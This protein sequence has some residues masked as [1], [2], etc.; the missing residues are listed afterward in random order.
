M[1]DDGDYPLNCIDD[2][3]DGF[4]GWFAISNPRQCNDFCYW[5]LPDSVQQ[6]T[7]NG[8]TNSTTSAGGGLVYA[9]WNTANPHKSTV[10]ST[11]SSGTSYWTCIYDSANDKTLVSLAQDERW[12][13]SFQKYYTPP[14]TT[15]EVVNK[16]VPFPYLKCQ[17]GAG[18]LLSSWS[19]DAVTS[20]TFWE[21]SVVLISF[22]FIGEFVTLYFIC[23]KRKRARSST[24]YAQVVPLD[25]GLDVLHESRQTL[26]SLHMTAE[27]DD[28]DS[29]EIQFVNQQ[30]TKSSTF[31]YSNKTGATSRCKF[32]NR[33]QLLCIFQ[34]LMVILL[35]ALLLVALS[36][37]SL[38]MNEIVTHSYYSESM[39]KFTP[40]CSDP[41]L[42][43][44]AG[45]VNIDKQSSVYSPLSRQS[46]NSV[47][48][49][50]DLTIK[51]IL[52]Q[53]GEEEVTNNNIMQPF[54]YII[55]SD[56]QLYWFNGEF[57][58]MG[59][60]ALPTS[61]TTSDSCARC[62]SKH[63]Q[64]TNRRLQ[65]AWES[66]MLGK[67]TGMN[68]ST[69]NSTDL[70]I[71]NTLIMNGDLTAYFHPW[72]KKAYDNIYT[73]IAGMKYYFPSLGN[74]DIEHSG[75]AMYGG[76]QWVGPPNCNMEHAI[77]YF[78][79]GFCGEIPGFDSDRIVR[80]DSS[81][82]AYSWDEGRFH[83]VHAHYYPSYEM[84]SVKY[85]SSLE[86]LERDLHI[87]HNSGLA[88][89]L[90]VHN[91]QG[92]N[93]AMESVILGKSVR[94]IIAGHN[95]RCLSRRCEGVY[96]MHEA[97]IS[98]LDPQ[99]LSDAKCIPAAYDTCQVLH[100][101]HMIYVKDKGNDVPFPQRKLKN[102]DRKDKPL[103]PK[104]APFFINE[105]DNSLLCRRVMYSQPHFPFDR[106]VN[107][108]NETIPIFWSGSASFE[109]FLR[110]DFYDDRF[111]I[112]AMTV[113]A[114]GGNVGRYMDLHT[115][116][117]AVYPYHEVSDIEEI[118]VY[119]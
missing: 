5:K 73:N 105:T 34:I 82:L 104:P 81:S 7:Q 45:N 36:F 111:V 115:V 15:T 78:K 25:D 32:C 8:T 70:P 101:E 119:L 19:G 40:A 44:P 85:R 48:Y 72:E 63:G 107:S 97:Q 54:S 16:D 37:F 66:L 46:V 112:N 67:T 92:L 69:D 49:E 114:E 24:R 65:Q 86:W 39:Q 11:P 47:K 43:C 117:N 35:N 26:S 21:S 31:L 30:A 103:C 58:N 52:Q 64:S 106:K 4:S 90:F 23:W 96:P 75:G 59:Q 93:E 61:C 118:V 18:E 9:A 13:D 99:E 42:I 51:S 38:S 50:D 62:T 110:V 55:A 53:Q 1:A 41:M 17:K 76:D 109:T 6:T 28:D 2:T 3:G 57:A 79:S 71:P 84:A 95:H 98:G 102:I 33:R 116:P 91:A 100:G 56:S 74:H 27:G 68:N 12:I 87:A 83:F 88:T 14:L 80:Y 113:S 29:E 20:A 60:Q 10:I 94:A 89:I 77:A 22:L 108:T